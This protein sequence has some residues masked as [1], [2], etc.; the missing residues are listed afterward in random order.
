M[1]CVG[2]LFDLVSQLLARFIV[3][4][5]GAEK[6]RIN[7]T[8]AVQLGLLFQHLLHHFRSFHVFPA[9][10]QNLRAKGLDERV[11]GLDRRSLLQFRKGLIVTRLISENSGAI[12]TGDDLLSRTQPRHALETTQSLVVLAVESRDHSSLKMNSPI[13]RSFAD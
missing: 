5:Q 7:R 3:E 6:R 11:I 2:G 13:V 9:I 8:N 10:K 1:V 4:A 12:I